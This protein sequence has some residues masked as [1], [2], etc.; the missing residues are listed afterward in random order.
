M[1][2]TEAAQHHHHHFCHRHHHHPF[3][4]LSKIPWGKVSTFEC[5]KADL[6]FQQVATHTNLPVDRSTCWRNN[7]RVRSPDDLFEGDTVV[8]WV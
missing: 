4:S 6:F 1:I 8:V 5:P 2:L 3:L 7:V